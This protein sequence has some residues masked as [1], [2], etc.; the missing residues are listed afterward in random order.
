MDNVII[1]AA[2]CGAEVT[3]EQ[4]PHV[5]YTAEELAKEARRC[6][7]A[8]ASIIHVHVRNDDG[9]PTQDREVFRKALRAIRDECGDLPIIQPSTGGAVGMTFEQRSQPLDLFPE[10]ATLDCGTVNFGDD[11]FVNDLPMMR[12]FGDMMMEREIV[13]ELEV[14]EIGHIHNALLL[15]KWGNHT[16]HMHFDLVLGVMGGMNGSWKSLTQCVDALPAGC[17]WTVAGIGRFE[18]PLAMQGL[19]MGGH[20]RVG[21]EDN[22]FYSKGVL[23]EGNAP[24][25]ERV[26]RMARELG[27]EP[28]TPQQARNLLKIPSDRYKRVKFET[29]D[30]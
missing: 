6:V 11:I 22:I 3:R 28:A 26:A 4:T 12:Q 23:S 9:T 19:A 1:T 15:Q 2:I 7:D 17:T 27:R 25:V 24:L 13:P 16:C 21:F 14:F 20:I 18:T 29:G 5:P 8:G 10:M 30:S